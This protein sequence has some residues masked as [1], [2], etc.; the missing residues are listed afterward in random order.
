MAMVF[1]LSLLAS[2]EIVAAAVVTGALGD[3]AARLTGSATLAITGHGLEAADAAAAR[4][5]EILIEAPGVKQARVLEPKPDDANTAALLGLVAEGPGAPVVRLETVSI[6]PGSSLSGAQLQ[7]LLRTRGV[8][9]AVDDH[10]AWSGPI[11][12]TALIGAITAAATEAALLLLVGVVVSLAT[13]RAVAREAARAKLLLH[14]GASEDLLARQF[15]KGAPIAATLAAGAGALLAA[16]LAAVTRTTP[17]AL[18][19]Q[20]AGLPVSSAGAWHLAAPLVWPILI[21]LLAL[22]IARGAARAAL[23]AMV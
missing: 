2:L 19:L 8:N 6:A 17:G 18:W 10:G 23:R 9:A 7:G 22:L 15:A 12:R 13:R 14:L 21:A 20:A 3:W 16:F 1:M 4:A 11:E 5:V